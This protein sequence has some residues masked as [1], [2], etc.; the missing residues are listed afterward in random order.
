MKYQNQNIRIHVD[1]AFK[2]IVNIQ[3][4]GLEIQSWESLFA[5]KKLF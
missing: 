4:L 5:L 3:C 1:L 2:E